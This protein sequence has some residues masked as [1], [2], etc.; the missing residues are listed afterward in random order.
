MFLYSRHVCVCVF[1]HTCMFC[2]R[3]VFS[4][5][6]DRKCYLSNMRKTQE[7]KTACLEFHRFVTLMMEREPRPERDREQWAAHNFTEKTQTGGLESHRWLDTHKRSIMKPWGKKIWA[8]ISRQ[9]L[10][11]SNNNPN[12]QIHLCVPKIQ[13]EILRLQVQVKVKLSTEFS[14]SQALCNKDTFHFYLRQVW[15]GSCVSL[16]VRVHV[17][18][19]PQLIFHTTGPISLTFFVHI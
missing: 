6:W 9:S 2:I 13:T 8:N 11:H 12:A 7:V 18:I 4:S 5:S 19:C 3:T 1:E 15:R 10:Y 14:L 17:Y 16:C